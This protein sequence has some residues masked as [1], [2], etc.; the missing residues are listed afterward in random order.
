MG[1]QSLLWVGTQQK[2]GSISVS[3][4]DVPCS[5]GAKCLVFAVPLPGRSA[6]YM[7][8][9]VQEACGDKAVVIVE[10]SRFLQLWR[11]EPFS[12]HANLAN[13]DVLSW[14]ND[15]KFDRATI[16]FS[17]GPSDPVPLAEVSLEKGRRMVTTHRFLRFGREQCEEEFHFVA[18]GNVTRT[19]WLLAHQCTAMPICC[20]ASSANDLHRLASVPDADFYTVSALAQS[21]AEQSRIECAVP[22]LEC[23]R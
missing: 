2:N 9:G 21:L 11:K 7:P 18:V 20:E 6:V 1:D 19:I 13:G 4:E 12:I 5:G 22:V 14:R 16:G 15:R 23:A 3:L 8:M 17:I 10:P